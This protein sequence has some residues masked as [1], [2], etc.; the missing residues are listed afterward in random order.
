MT[1]INRLH[2][3]LVILAS[4]T[5]YAFPC[6]AQ[7]YPSRP[8][9]ILDGFP[10]GGNTDF[11][12]RIVGQ[13]L[14]ESWGQPVVVDNRPG[15]GGN[16]AAEA[17]AKSPPDGY[18]LFNGLLGALAPSMALYPKLQYH[19]V[20]DFAPVGVVASSLFVLFVHPSL[21]VKSLQ[22]LVALAKARPG[23]LNYASCGVGCVTHL[24]AEALKLH[25]RVNIVHVPYKGGAP[26][27]A[28]VVGGESALTFGSLATSLALIK[29]G[30][31]RVIAVSTLQRSKSLPEIPTIA[32]SGYPGFDITGWY[33]LFAPAG[34]PAPIISKLNSELVR[35][36]KLPAVIERLSTVDLEPQTG[37]PEQFGA[38]VKQEI[39]LYAKLVKEAGIKAE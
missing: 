29:A 20:R 22:D 2:A 15:A 7:D 36:F 34:T 11:L 32:E 35:I 18:T 26:A 28:S 13:R 9:R 30:K 38:I 6:V 27:T 5:L 16:I 37:T 10:P 17:A 8:I 39:A 14:S 24:A 3:A 23:E 25:A 21:P 19:L 33:G 4:A 1:R 31:I 12:S